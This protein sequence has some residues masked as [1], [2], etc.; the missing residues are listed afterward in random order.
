MASPKKARL[1]KPRPKTAVITG[2]SGGIG[3]AVAEMLALEGFDLVVAS[4]QASLAATQA[5]VA[6]AGAAAVE[7]PL[8]A[9]D[10]DS[11]ERF[12]R[13]AEATLGRVD[14]FVH[15]A[16]SYFRGELFALGPADFDQLLRVNLGSFYYLTRLFVPG[17]I[18]RRYGRIV[19]FGLSGTGNLAAP[20]KIAAHYV[21]KAG[22]VAFT[23][24]LAKE[25]APHSITANVISPGFI[26]TGTMP[27]PELAEALARIPAGRLGT[28]TEAASLV[29]FLLSDQ[30]AYLTGADIPLSGGYRL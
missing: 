1:N 14:A 27:P 28:P 19:A 17:M 11:C 8:D 3:R 9:T 25:L 13:E 7:I 5:A 2:A 30:A 26:D 16:G 4:H 20:P 23:R 22:I 15:A 10:P 29:R 21:A 18:E 6:N 12:A 24:A